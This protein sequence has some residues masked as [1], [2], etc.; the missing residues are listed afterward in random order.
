MRRLSIVLLGFFFLL[1]CVEEREPSPVGV[2]ANSGVP[3]ITSLEIFD[4]TSTS[5]GANPHFFFLPP[6]AEQ[7]PAFEGIADQSLEP[8]VTICPFGLWDTGGESCSAPL[9][10]FSSD[11]S[12]PGPTVSAGTDDY[13]V[14]W[15]TNEFPATQ[16][17][18]YRIAVSIGGE[19]ATRFLGWVDVKAYDQQTYN[20]FTHTDPEG[21][22]AIS[23]NGN[24]NIKFRIEDGAP[25]YE[26]CDPDSVEDCDV[27][28]FTYGEEGCL[29]VFDN[30]GE[31]GEVLGSQACVPANA[32]MVDG[33][34]VEG[35]YATILTLE[36]E[37]VFQG[38]SV[39]TSLQ[40]RFFSDVEFFPPNLEFD[41]D[42][43][44]VGVVICQV[45]VTSEPGYI[46][47]DLHP[48]LRPFIVY[49]DG[50]TV[51][52]EN[53]SFGAPECEGF[54]THT[55]PLAAGHG[56]GNTLLGR[57]ATSLSKVSSFFLPTPLVARRLHG[58]LNTTVY[59]S[60][61][62]DSPGGGE[63][64][65]T[66]LLG[67]E[68]VVV[69]FGAILNVDPLN[70]T[71]FPP[72]TG[73][74]GFASSFTINA[75]NAQ[76][77]PYPFE[78][79]V[80]VDVLSG[81]DAV[82][83]AVTYDGD[84]VYTATYTPTT[85]GTDVITITIDGEEMAGSPYS[86]NIAPRNVDPA[87]SSFEI[88][89]SE[90]GLTTTVTILVVDTKGDP[91]VYGAD[92]PID[93]QIAV[94]GANTATATATDPDGDGYYVATYD[95]VTYGVD[96]ITATIGGVVTGDGTKTVTTAPRPVDP[97]ASL[98]TLL[99][100]GDV[101]SGGQVDAPTNISIVV[102]ND[103]G[104]SYD[105]GSIR[106]I[107]VQVSVAG[108]T[109]VASFPATD[110]GNGTYEAAYTPLE[111]GTDF[112]TILIDG[113]AIGGS[114][115]E[116]AIAPRT[117]DASASTV[118]VS[119]SVDGSP[120][121][122]TVTVKDSDGALYIYGEDFPI[123]VEVV[124]TGSNGASVVAEDPDGDGIYVASYTPEAYGDDEI[125]V[126][127]NGTPTGD[128]PISI[129]TLPRPVDPSQ[130]SATLLSAA[131]EVAPGDGKVDAQTD[132]TVDVR[133]TAGD[134]YDYAA[135]Y[136]DD[137]TIDVQVVVSGANTV[138]SFPATDNGDGTY[139]AA[140]TPTAAG[141]DNVAITIDG[142]PIS[143]S[144]YTSEVAPLRGD[145][146]V[147]IDITGPGIAPEDGLPVNLYSGIDLVGTAVTDGSGVATFSDV[148]FG[149]YTVHLP[150]RDFDADFTTMTKVVDH[151][152]TPSNT[153]FEAFSQTL[154]DGVFVYRVKEDGN[155]NAFQYVLNNRSWVS[156]QNQVKDDVLLGVS[157]HL[158]TIHTEGENTFVAGLVGAECPNETNENRCKYQGWI[159]LTDTDS[160]G[161]FQ[162]VTGESLSFTNWK[163]GEPSGK[164]NEDH[165]EI[166]LFGFWTDENG[167]SSN[168]EGYV[169]EWEVVWPN[170]PPF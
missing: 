101:A 157:G 133:N 158:A 113:Q 27:E 154:P 44:G 18:V 60:S 6:V 95:P 10:V 8:A 20:S 64:V 155:G 43:E 49:A 1:G 109:T 120:T 25:E 121:T 16:G 38:G 123:D 75:L 3:G 68:E 144:P 69:E 30:P 132:I 134:P 122:V 104:E 65:S 89:D 168:N 29:R 83:G 4:G 127:I 41:T 62:D 50:T 84:G 142:T 152:S 72:A 103:A 85:V 78:V 81:T 145:L 96:E 26:F 126:T 106:P 136:P 13:S 24:L 128:S 92:F 47:E 130:S 74:V 139:L 169:V 162:W 35:V 5:P 107:D 71:A 87:G 12:A 34:P 114:P 135:G 31:G 32:A 46:P 42:S 37:E 7:T 141:T 19:T 11:P 14:V 91:Y 58:G 54:G 119:P 55:E 28:L 170:T 147:T 148:L 161:S 48:Q 86:S 23:D 140:Y 66:F 124:V 153:T 79:P 160:E 108:A 118:E 165:V 51:L 125:T 15:R 94:T 39:P 90:A 70:S 166:N 76:G 146:T 61:G 105:Y 59:R 167:A 159:G 33:A 40:V 9:A 57:F 137:R 80:T 129:T 138:A 22:V 116:S 98:A 150:K 110:A 149:S 21:F 97:A 67:E 63:A 56:D 112:V 77:L 88:S 93:V 53:Y 99:S 82:E 156:A 2:D 151:Q 100:T 143:G 115:Y 164:N 111:V 163:V 73:Q 102:V 117:V 131:P 45:A 36:K 17:Q 52:P